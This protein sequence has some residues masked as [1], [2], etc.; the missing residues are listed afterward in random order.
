[1]DSRYKQRYKKRIAEGLCVRC[2]EHYQGEAKEC[3]DCRAYSAQH[4]TKARNLAIE[5]VFDYYSS[6]CVCCGEKE[7]LFLSLDHVDG[8]GRQEHGDL[9]RRVVREGFPPKYRVLCMNCNLGRFRN[10]GICP[11]EQEKAIQERNG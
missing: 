3:P 10:G 7:R 6:I 2:G 9:Y 8:G 4:Q 5:A 11:H 1:M